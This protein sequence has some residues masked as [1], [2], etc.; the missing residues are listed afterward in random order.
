VI[1]D[2]DP[3]E[4]VR[5]TV[6]RDAVLA[7]IADA[8]ARADRD[9]SSVRLVAISKTVAP[10]RVRAAAV[11]GQELFGENRVQEAVDKRPR[12]GAGSWH[13]VGPLQGNKARRAIETFDAIQSVDTLD[14]ARRLDRLVREVRALPVVGPVADERRYSVLLQ[15][16]VDGDASKAGFAPSALRAALPELAALGAVRLAGCMTIGRLVEVPEATR[17]TFRSLRE[18]AARARVVEPALGPELSMGMSDDYPI[19][20]EEGATIVRVGRA[21]FGERA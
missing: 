21:L 8:C 15:V 2:V 11:A 4:V 16:N 5:F 12:V 6:A 3:A 7:R 9:P 10:E 1:L 18:L 13:L 19:A 14:L 17:P 20:V